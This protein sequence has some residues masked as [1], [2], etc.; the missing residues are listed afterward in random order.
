M[1]L[2]EV[3]NFNSDASCLD[4]K[5]WLGCLQG[6]G[7]SNF[8]K[9]LDSYVQADRKTN[10]GLTAATIHDLSY[11][12]PEAIHF[13]NE[14]SD[15]FQLVIR[16]YA[17]DSPLLR[18]PDGFRFNLEKGIE[19]ITRFFKNVSRSYLQPEII[20]TGEQISILREF[21]IDNIFI[22]R[23]RYHESIRKKIPCFPFQILG[24]L[25]S[26]ISCIP[27]THKSLETIYLQALHG[28]ISEQIW[29]DQIAKEI[30]GCIDESQ[31]IYIWRDGE[32]C[33]LVPKGIQYEASILQSEKYKRI[34]RKLLS[35]TNLTQSGDAFSY[36]S[37]NSKTSPISFFPAYSMK[38][39][40]NEMK[41]YWFIS[42]VHEIELRFSDLSN[43]EKMLWLML[44]NS[45]ILS[46]IERKP[47]VIAVSRD[48]FCVDPQ[49]ISWIGV[50]AHPEK[51]KITLLRSERS[52]EAEDYL[53]YWQKVHEHKMSIESLLETWSSSQKPYL[54]KAYA[55]V[56]GL[57]H[58]S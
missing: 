3:I 24:T 18:L 45:D 25:G 55:R 41:L 49:D 10:L 33:L 20:T 34:E 21:G 36:E 27:F 47:P 8:V 30:K 19:V 13:I 7:K 46:S 37:E 40:L 38:P 17:H 29:S 42:R 11:F 56:R 2:V 4:A 12:N 26:S 31:D 50:L 57:I 23:Y 32:S 16:P 39:W 28:V 51:G 44:I 6:G 54:Q 43:I 15:I 14:H 22:H 53:A 5:K 58:Y 35:E 52:G 1:S 9:M 48:I